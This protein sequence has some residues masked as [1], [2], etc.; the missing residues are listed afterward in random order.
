M[1]AFKFLFFILALI[2]V[3]GYSQITGTI[4]DQFTN[5][6]LQGASI[7]IL[8]KNHGTISDLHGQFKIAALPGDVLF[9]SYVGY[10]SK[11]ISI[12][13]IS[14]LDIPLEPDTKELDE[15]IVTGVFDSRKRIE[16][17]VAITTIST[18]QLEHIVPNS[19]S[20]LLRMIPGVFVQSAR[21][22]LRNQIYSRGMVFDGSVYLISMQED[23]L[24]IVSGQSGNPGGYL[25]ADVN[26]NKIEAVR[27]G[28]AS[29]LGVNAPGGIFNY[30]SKTGGS[31]FD[32]VL[33]T[34]LGL[35]GNG[36]NPYLRTEGNI[37][38]PLSKDKSWTYNIGGHYRHANGAKYPGYPLSH[39]GQI[40]GNLIKTYSTGSLKLYAKWLNDHTKDFEFTPTVDFENPRPAGNFKNYSSVLIDALKLTLPSS[41]E[42]VRTI[43]YDSRDLNHLKDNSISLHWEQRLGDSW[44][45][46]HV[47]KLSHKR[48]TDVGTF[49]V[50]PNDVTSFFFNFV[51]D[52]FG[53]PG[54]YK[55][56]NAAT[57]QE[58]GIL[59]QDFTNPIPFNFEGKL[60]GSE[61]IPNGVFFTPLTYVDSDIND[62]FYQGTFSKIWKNMKFTGG[63][64][65]NKSRLNY[66]NANASAG[67]GLSTIEDKPQLVAIEYSP[68]DG[69]PVQQF[70]DPLGAGA[71]N[72]GPIYAE[73]NDIKTWD[74]AVFFGHQW[75][76]NERLNLDWGARYEWFQISNSYRRPTP[77]EIS[78]TGGFDHNPLTI[79]DN[80]TG[81]LTAPVSYQKQAN[82]YSY[83][84]GIN[85][86]QNKNLAYYIRYSNGS[87]VPD[88]STFTASQTAGEAA[89]VLPQTTI[90]LEGGVKYQTKN[91]SL[92]VTPF[93]SVLSGIPYAVYASNSVGAD[94]SFYNLPVL[95]NKAHAIGVELE[96]TV[97][98]NSRWSVRANAVIQ[99][100]FTDKYQTWNTRD[101]GPK[102]DTIVDQSGK[103]ISIFA[104]P[105]IFNITP[106]Y[107]HKKIYA[108]LNWYSLSRRSANIN[109]AF[110]LPAVNQFDLNL[111]Y[112]I[113]NKINLKLS[114]NNL[115]NHFG[116]MDWTAPITNGIFFGTFDTSSVTKDTI[117]SNPNANY[118]TMGIQ[119]RSFFLDLAFKL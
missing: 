117:K 119:P 74:N 7:S 85:Y 72:Y 57:R 46:N 16:S 88:I 34:R 33:S 11:Q 115:F 83:S 60:P 6:K 96:T 86:R 90:Q 118:Y 95:Y 89:N 26:L 12:T 113:S 50:Y 36:R 29:I 112:A 40:K 52:L 77:N 102:D 81:S 63:L 98:L 13:G 56:F 42:G 22:E 100:F 38:G 82:A 5:E 58:Y 101:V 99:Q 48:S 116:V 61:I 18:K 66:Y 79:Y 47:F 93:L 78:T 45:T 27:G 31:Q 70:T 23:G 3:I 9:I 106:A 91:T 65:S 54:K 84:A 41:G 68:A 35:E 92:T 108:G 111:A 10:Q 80:Y 8:G 44:K 104:A 20:E 17:S 19:S 105:Y 21:G 15:I 73:Q 76:I 2:P 28:S 30:I 14:Y 71:Y 109:D 59:T 69:G 24:P 114:I 97:Q 51:F 75:D 1:R 107:Q 39:G 62:F 110:Y 53:K 32:G 94:A 103:K 25:R 55:F 49:I 4:I 37:G 43:D 64:Y 87:K 67:T